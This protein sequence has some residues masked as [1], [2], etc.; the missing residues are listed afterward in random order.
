MTKEELQ[1]Y[2]NLRSE[3][4]ML[5]ALKQKIER[6]STDELRAKYAQKC[7]QLANKLL[8]I[9]QVIE[10]LNSTERMILRLRY[11]NGLSWLSVCDRVHYSWQQTH[12]I[13]ARALR[14]I[15]KL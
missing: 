8:R 10:K 13:H 6:H 15:E 2:R 4:K 3:L 12:R 11:I 1:N 9:E 7:E 5:D 14:K